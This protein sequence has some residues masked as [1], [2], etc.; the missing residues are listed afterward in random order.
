MDL[1]S[2]STASSLVFSAFSTT[3]FVFSLSMTGIFNT[4]HTDTVVPIV[5]FYGGVILLL[6][7]MVSF[8]ANDMFIATAGLSY[9]GFWMAMGL[10][11]YLHHASLATGSDIA[12]FYLAW[13]VFTLYVW[14]ASWRRG[15]VTNFHYVLWLI[16]L[17]LMFVCG[18]TANSLIGHIG[19]WFAF[20]S[21][22]V[23]WYIAAGKLLESTFGKTFLKLGKNA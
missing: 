10:I 9:A 6:A 3:L 19:A 1:A 12:V 15:V 20:A 2:R 4:S 22:I 21:S 13:A 17:I 18:F 8:K 7:G 14:A 23:G 16:A 5:F 11:G